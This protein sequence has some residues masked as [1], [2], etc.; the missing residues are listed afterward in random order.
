ME[1]NESNLALLEQTNPGAF[2][3]NKLTPNGMEMLYASP[4]A[5]KIVGME[6]DEYLA[7]SHA[8]TLSAVLEEDRPIIAAEA[9]KCLRGEG[10]MDAVYRVRHKAKGYIWIHAKGRIIGT[11]N[12]DPIVYAV[13]YGN[14]DA[15]ILVEKNNELQNLV[16]NIP[17]T[18]FIYKKQNND[19][20]I[21][22]TNAHFRALP[23]ASRLRPETMDESEFLHLIHPN[24]RGRAR[25]FFA[26]LF[27]SGTQSEMTYRLLTN[28]G[29]AYRW[30]H[31][32]GKPVLQPDGSIL[33]YVVFTDI[34]AE[35]EAE[36]EALK[37]QQMYRLTA[38]QARQ[39]IFE[40]DQE[41]RRILYQMDSDY[42][43]A[44]CEAQGMPAIVENVPESL[45]SMVD[46]PYREQFLSLF[47][48]MEDGVP[49]PAVE[50]STVINGQTHWWRVISAPVTDSD[51]R[52]VTVYCSAQD[53]TELKREQQR[54]MDFFQSLDN[55]YPNNLGSFHLNLTKNI[56]IDGKSPLAFVMKQK[57]SG[58]VDG[59]FSEFSKLIA[60]E[61]TLAWFRRE[62]TCE[63][64]I[65]SFREG[66]TAASFPY[67]IRY[68]D[69]L[70]WR[71][72]ILVMHRNPRTEDIEAVT[73]AVD[74]DN[75][76]RGDMILQL[77]SGEGSD[78]I[79]F[80]DVASGTFVM[81]SGNGNCCGLESGQRAPYGVC[82]ERLAGE[83]CTG[84]DSPAKLRVQASLETITAALEKEKK[85]SILYDFAESA[86]Q[87]LKKQV[88]FQWF[89]EEKSEILVIQA[90]VT[91][92]WNGEQERLRRAE[93]VNTLEDMVANIPVGIMVISAAKG[94]RLSLV[95]GNDRIRQLLGGGY[96]N[97]S[98]FF[99][100]VH[101]DDVE[102]VRAAVDNGYASQLP[103]TVDYRYS[104]KLGGSFCW[105][106]LMVNGAE[107]KHGELLVYCCLLDI[108]EEKAA[109]EARN[110]AQR[111][112]VR[113]YETQLNMMA[114]AN[115][116]F[117]A[118]YHLNI[119]K[120]QCTNMVV[121]D[122]AYAGL[123]KLAASGTASGL[124]EA[125]ADTIPDRAIAAQVRDTFSCD[126]LLRRFEQGES[127]ISVEYPCRSV[128]GGVRWMLGSVN[129]VRN[130]E[131]GDVEGV[132]Y[133]VDINEQRKSEL[134]TSRVAEQEFEYIGILYLQ[135]EEVEFVRKKAHV[136]YP[137]IGQK[138]PYSARR[139]F[140]QEHFISPPEEDSYTRAT[141]LA[142]IKSELAA[143]GTYTL[144]YLQTDDIGRRTCQ[145][146]RYSWLDEAHR[147]VLVVQTDVTASYEHE[148]KQIADIQS[149]LMEA[150]KA[151]SA[152]SD[153]VSRISHDI[154]TPIGAIANITG[155]AQEDIDN[156]EKLKDDL[157]KIQ[158][159][160]EFLL[161]LINDVL[162]ISKIDSGKIELHP[163]PYLYADFIS[164][165]CN[166][167]E[168]LCESKGIRFEIDQQ[169]VVPFI[170]VDRVRLNQIMMNLISN[171]VK[172]TPKGGAVTVSAAG[173]RR[174]DGQCDCILT[175][176][177]TGIGMSGEFQKTMFD[178]FTQE[179]S[180]PGRD[181]S[182][183]GTG[184]GLSLV[185]KLA[186]LMGGTIAVKSE[187]GRGTA[188]SIS[189][190]AA[191]AGVDFVSAEKTGGPLSETAEG[192][193]SGTV[194]LAED[195]A[196]NTE[197][198]KRIL[199]KLGLSVVHAEN[200][201]RAVELF[202]ASA[203][204]EYRAVLMDIQMPVM[205]GYDATRAIRELNRP[206][207]KSVPIIAMTADAFTAAI[208]RSMAVGMTDYVTKP[209]NVDLLREALAK[210]GQGL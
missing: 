38:E 76:K 79:G 96:Q 51:G 184:L 13:F 176:S 123:K 94:K 34:T 205:N 168:P 95:T 191:E 97:D 164:S 66:N 124:F 2:T 141:D 91:G 208:E 37:S 201:A 157:R 167:F 48:P 1:I 81:H 40:Y 89:D 170:F 54:Y 93:E 52:V 73:Y 120:D 127:K 146:V 90:D 185:R 171:A 177:D 101:P 12:G 77:M 57:E 121:Q 186:E 109:E 169:P 27:D 173:K 102:K 26:A 74:I 158:V 202:S 187:L 67:S 166:M 163:E 112:E 108:T 85:Y 116:S 98:L 192:K 125:T 144:S 68:P 130:P 39:I 22:Y 110:E 198:A 135:T 78:Y 36:L 147:I 160:N 18:V 84:A 61:K 137:E 159:S 71:Q 153:F 92:V 111:L 21:T 46:E 162:D 11:L 6:Q 80:I 14:P 31:L 44:I 62:F 23:F 45:V 193:L 143:N 206:D 105:H 199:E 128:R 150:E 35:K 32:S 142:Q 174:A 33:A 195:N 16:D 50:Y 207:A 138:I 155:F 149:A 210:S 119:T 75:Q 145:Q 83:Y 148:E 106:R 152:K 9:E 56:C 197:I 63:A 55:A 122:E 47:K 25:A 165:I 115:P 15:D 99:L 20:R 29:S 49:R 41:H 129:M 114:L 69:G 88:T 200:G 82:L 104:P 132:T 126:R 136:Q 175:V 72:A 30:L 179:E 190:I 117:A 42:T 140:V 3:I 58:T 182:V 203:P 64:L 107:Q 161:S 65:R 7:S 154:R 139:H 189:F 133:A 5:A 53:I 8:D 60:D 180:N 134:V 19:L 156:P 196:I 86:G 188:I 87:P 113:K 103:F 204:G 70:R 4:D 194:I 10:D 28:R 131:S 118:S 151:C 100:H 17:A 209:L 172:Y 24:D 43:R 178:P 181:K 59:Y 183:Q